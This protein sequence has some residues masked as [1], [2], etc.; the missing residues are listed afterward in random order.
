MQ[1]ISLINWLIHILDV[2]LYFCLGQTWLRRTKKGEYLI[3]LVESG[4][5]NWVHR[6]ANAELRAEVSALQKFFVQSLIVLF[7]TLFFLAISP[8][9]NLPV[10][11]LIMGSLRISSLI[12]FIGL[13]SLDWTFQ[14]RYTLR[15][16]LRSLLVLRAILIFALAFVLTVLTVKPMLEQPLIL[17]SQSL[18]WGIPS[19]GLIYAFIIIMGIVATLLGVL[20]GFIG[21]WVFF[22]GLS[23]LIVGMLY[24]TSLLSRFLVAKVNHDLAWQ[25]VFLAS[26]LIRFIKPLL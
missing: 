14:Q 18:G 26:V 22:G 17:I 4:V 7:L 16:Y 1:H 12:A 10:V 11:Q 15:S 2:S 5:A 24:T 13:V 3:N 25:L 21:G 6:R 8:L 20:I 19:E 9:K 23:F